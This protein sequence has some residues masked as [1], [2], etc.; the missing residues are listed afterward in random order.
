MQK[1]PIYKKKK[2]TTVKKAKKDPNFKGAYE[3]MSEIAY[4]I[5]DK[6]HG[7]FNVRKSANSWWM[8]R[9]KLERLIEAKKAGLNDM[10]AGYYTGITKNQ[11][12]YFLKIHPH[13]S[14]FFDSLGMHPRT[15]AKFTLVNNLHDVDVAKWYA[16]HKMND[17]FSRRSEVSMKNDFDKLSDEEINKELEELERKVQ[18]D[19]SGENQE[20]GA[21]SGEAEE[22]T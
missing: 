6:W 2:S 1:P 19:A 14:E 5:E 16:E 8:D 11:K 22:T 15:K 18:I 13:F 20:D 7:S 21:S 3:F 17:E 10:E 9:L 12:D 4:T